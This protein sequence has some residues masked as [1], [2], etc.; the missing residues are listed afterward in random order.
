MSR[1]GKVLGKVQ[2]LPGMQH[3][4]NYRF[5]CEF[6]LKY[7]SNWSPRSKSYTFL[8]LSPI[9]KTYLNKFFIWESFLSAFLFLL[10]RNLV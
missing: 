6:V 1:L 2:V 4:N 9:K 10:L 5:D 3:T 8:L 7:Y